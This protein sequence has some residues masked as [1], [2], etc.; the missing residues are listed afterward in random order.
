MGSSN[1]D[2]YTDEVLRIQ[3]LV[4]VLVDRLAELGLV[5]DSTIL[6]LG[7]LLSALVE[8]VESVEE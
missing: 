1:P 4:K 6:E 5:K 7:H 3:R 2:R 8:I